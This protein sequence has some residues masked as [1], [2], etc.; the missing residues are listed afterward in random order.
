MVYSITSRDSFDEIST[1][2]QRILEVKD[3]KSFF[4]AVVVANKCDLI[5]ER[6]VGEH[7]DFLFASSE[8]LLM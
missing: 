3:Q 8:I 2:H 7:G 6:Q 5:H 4:P 1:Y